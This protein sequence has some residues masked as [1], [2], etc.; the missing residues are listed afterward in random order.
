LLPISV[1]A[2]TNST[3]ISVDD[4]AWTTILLVHQHTLDH[5]ADYS[6]RYYTNCCSLFSHFS[7]MSIGSSGFKSVNR[8]QQTWIF[9]RLT[10]I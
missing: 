2:T 1:K 9:Y 4:W 5:I 8:S 3:Q 10:W 7:P 6:Q